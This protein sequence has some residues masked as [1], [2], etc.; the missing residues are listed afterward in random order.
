MVSQASPID[1]KTEIVKGESKLI[2]NHL[3][4]SFHT[5]NQEKL[6]NYGHHVLKYWPKV[7]LLPQSNISL[8]LF[9][10]QNTLCRVPKGMLFLQH[11]VV[12]SKHEFLAR[13]V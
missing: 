12:I 1:M 13:T 2:K 8:I 11:K 5:S 7:I 4:Q 3:Y 6:L 9:F 10:I